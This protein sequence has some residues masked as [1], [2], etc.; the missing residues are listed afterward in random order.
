MKTALYGIIVLLC[1]ASPAMAA[2]EPQFN[3]K[4]S[5]LGKPDETSSKGSGAFTVSERE[6]G[7]VALSFYGDGA[8]FS[9]QAVGTKQYPVA[10]QSKQPGDVNFSGDLF[11][12]ADIYLR[13]NVNAENKIHL[14][15]QLNQMT[16]IL[17]QPQPQPIYTY[18]EKK[19][20]FVLPN[21]GEQFL[22]LNI[23]Q[24]GHT[25]RLKIT[26][27]GPG[28]LVYS[29]K[30]Y[31]Q[32]TFQNSYSLFNETTDKYELEGCK[33]TLSFPVDGEGG[34]GNSNY[35]RVYHLENGKVL[36]YLASF[37][38]DNVKWNDDHTLSFDFNATHIYAINPK[39]TSASA[40]ELSSDKTTI[41]M[42]NRH[43]TAQPGEQTEIEIPIN[44]NSLLPFKGKEKIVLTNSVE[45]KTY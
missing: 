6:F 18:I 45:E 11:M 41:V 10:Y 34:T 33:S 7:R 27:T 3:I 25:I 19:L 26:V 40:T 39:D 20:D 31:R 17:N 28:P 2:D 1:I 43:I 15:G 44:K 14:T 8:N 35:R 37:D 4:I 36:L 23:D 30:T 38:I 9:V 13:P 24:S 21:G 29:P 12:T 5:V 42:L 22:D 16:R 32:A